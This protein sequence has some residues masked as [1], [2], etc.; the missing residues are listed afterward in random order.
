M[1]NKYF[2]VFIKRKTEFLPSIEI[3]CPKSEIF[4]LILTGW[5]ESGKVILQVS[6]AA[7]SFRALSNNFSGKDGSAP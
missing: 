2:F 7:L 6:I 4:L 3:K 1:K 5:G